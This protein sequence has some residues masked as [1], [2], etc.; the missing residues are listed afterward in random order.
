MIEEKALRADKDALLLAEY[1]RM[2]PWTRSFLKAV[3]P[4][5]DDTDTSTTRLLSSVNEELFKGES[6]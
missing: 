5:Y 1:T 6:M 2:K 3:A 4:W